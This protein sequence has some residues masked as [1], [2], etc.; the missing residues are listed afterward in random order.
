[1]DSSSSLNRILIVDYAGG[2]P[3]LAQRFSQPDVVGCYVRKRRAAH[4]T[5]CD[6]LIA[7]CNFAVAAANMTQVDNH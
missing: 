3:L 1:V 6:K 5:R 2:A 7:Q 4:G